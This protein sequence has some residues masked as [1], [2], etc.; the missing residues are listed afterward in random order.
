MQ[1]LQD[2]SWKDLEVSS[3]RIAFIVSGVLHKLPSKSNYKSSP[4]VKLTTTTGL[5]R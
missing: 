3:L 2:L 4:A 1:D 5:A